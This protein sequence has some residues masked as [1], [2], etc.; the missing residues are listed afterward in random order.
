MHFSLI[1]GTIN[2]S[3]E[4]ERFLKHLDKQTYRNFDLII[5]DQNQDS[6]LLSILMPYKKSFCIQYLHS[7]PGLSRARNVGLKYVS[8][9]VIA[10][11]DDDCW[12]PPDLL[13]YVNDIFHK[14]PNIDGLTGCSKDEHGRDSAGR[15]D[16]KSGIVKKYNVWIRGRSITIFL[17]S[18]V[19]RQV[20][21]FDELL[22]IGSETVWGAGEETDYLLRILK[23]NYKIYYDPNL[24]IYHP[25]QS[26]IFDSKTIMK[27]KKYG[28][29]IGRV[30]RK[31]RYP[32]WF[33][34]YH[35]FRSM[36]GAFLSLVLGDFKK[37]KL[38]LAAMQGKFIGWIV[39]PKSH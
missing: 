20:G 2:R 27:A 12:Y 7:I 15:Y 25:N 35:I 19:V 28:A 34:I 23:L 4:L 31:H 6:K 37:S 29:G 9:N 24:I 21:N 39:K 14:Y 11:P 33:I 26:Q 30:M 17:K 8:G 13:E 1:L 38:H 18:K 32:L 16:F 10:F 22:G 5:V 3:K 36:G